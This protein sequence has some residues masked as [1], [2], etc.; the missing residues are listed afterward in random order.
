MY[1]VPGLRASN[2]YGLAGE[3]ILNFT[4][5]AAP[6]AFILLGLV[7]ARVRYWL[8][9]WDHLDSRMLL[10]PFLVIF[11]FLVLIN[12]LDNN[13]IYIAQY[14]LI[15]IFVIWI[16]SRKNVISNPNEDNVAVENA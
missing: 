3:A 16:G 8:Q 15:S 1:D 4:P 2:I 14:G 13:M 12:D 5:L 9:S 6:I 10:I 7:V 11:A